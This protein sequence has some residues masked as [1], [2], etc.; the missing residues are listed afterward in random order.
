MQQNQ[1][2]VF[3]IGEYLFKFRDFFKNSSVQYGLGVYRVFCV[4]CVR[5]AGLHILLEWGRN[6]H[7]GSDLPPSPKCAVPSAIRQAVPFLGSLVQVSSAPSVFVAVVTF[8][9]NLLSVSQDDT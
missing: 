9:Q 1:S 2:F 3:K 8:K 5:S 4:W 6:A 7:G